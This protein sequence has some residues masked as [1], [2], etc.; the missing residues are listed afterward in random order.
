M[1]SAFVLLL[2]TN[3]QPFLMFGE[4]PVAYFL[5]RRNVLLPQAQI[6]SMPT[7]IKCTGK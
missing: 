2:S 5:A 4:Y 1:V 3:T 7:V 6:I